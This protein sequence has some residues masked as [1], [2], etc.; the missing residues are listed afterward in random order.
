MHAMASAFDV[1]NGPIIVTKQA[2]GAFPSDPT[3]VVSP[4]VIKAPP[5]LVAQ[6]L[7]H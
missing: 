7:I 3:C 6:G 5:T 2:L 4:R 1:V